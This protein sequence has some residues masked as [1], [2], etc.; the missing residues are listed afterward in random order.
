MIRARI[1]RPPVRLRI[2][3]EDLRQAMRDLAK[4]LTS[5]DIEPDT[6]EGRGFIRGLDLA[7]SLIR[8]AVDS[9][10]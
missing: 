3:D 10:G 4:G 8:A 1:P 6:P 7:A 2:A 9:R 5:H